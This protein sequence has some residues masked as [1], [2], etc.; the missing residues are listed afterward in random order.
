MQQQREVQQLSFKPQNYITHV[1]QSPAAIKAYYVAH[2]KDFEKPETAQID[3]VVLS[4]SALAAAYHPSDSELQQYYQS[5]ITRY[6]TK[7]QVR[8]SHILIAVPKDASAQEVATAQ[9]KAAAI[10]AEVRAHPSRFATLA[11]QDSQ[12]SGSAAQGGD[13]GFFGRDM[14]VKPF[15]D[16]AFALKKGQISDLVRTDFGFHIIQVT[17]IRPATTQP[18][19]AVKGSIAVA[20]Q[21]QQGAKQFANN[22]EGFSD[23]VYQAPANSL[24]PAARQYHLTIQHATVTPHPN[25]TLASTD[26][27][28]NPQFLKAVFSSDAVKNGHNTDAIDVG[29]NTLIAAHVTRHTPA[30]VPEL[31]AIQAQVR[32]RYL[33]EQTEQLARQAGTAK[34]AQLQKSLSADGFSATAKIARDENSIVFPSAA[35]AQIF[36]LGDHPLPQYAGVDLGANGYRIYRLNKI[37]QSQ[38]I[39]PGKLAAITRQLTQLSAQNE[40][41]A[42][43]ASLRAR[44]NVK[45]Y[46]DS[47]NSATNPAT[48]STTD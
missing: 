9:Q 22:M 25:P 18:F 33:A 48:G 27:L 36:K 43:Y 3:Y 34:L 13:L 11:K 35:V 31:Q 37:D 12:D 16:A 28:N 41:A 30:E 32:Q 1:D 10:L 44:S 19:E 6:R 7:E 17:D 46:E 2:A 20:L 14:M 29:N 8:A 39:D 4:Q 21:G 38:G 24:Q 40:L 23:M 42:Y 47:L 15:E 45:L 5:N 26:P